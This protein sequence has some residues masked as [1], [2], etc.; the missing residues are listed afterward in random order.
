MI[1]FAL[2]LSLLVIVAFG[3]LYIR[4]LL[5]VI[6]SISEDMLVIKELIESYKEGLQN[7]YETEMF[8]G[9]PVLQNLVEHSKE[10]DSELAKILADYDFS[11]LEKE[12]QEP[13]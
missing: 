1:E 2:I 11:E 5:T 4:Y 3:T 13:S 8:F 6:R 9:E 10:L 12:E 7:V